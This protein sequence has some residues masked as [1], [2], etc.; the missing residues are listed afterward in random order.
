MP[1]SLIDIKSFNTSGTWSGNVYTWNGVTFTIHDDFSVTTGGTFSQRA[2][3]YLQST[4]TSIAKDTYIASGCPSG[5]STT[6]YRI[7][8]G[9][10]DGS[11]ASTS[12]ADTGDG[13]NRDVTTLST[14]KI[15]CYIDIR[16]SSGIGKTF[17]PMLRLSTITD[18]S[19]EPYTGRNEFT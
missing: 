10:Y 4:P 14:P 8:N 9:T 13:V 11:T 12:F 16:A 5:G 17:Y 1:M 7:V 3:L 18:G 19:Y 6:T 2:Y 15:W